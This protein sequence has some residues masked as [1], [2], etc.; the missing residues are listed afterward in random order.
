M[1]IIYALIFFSIFKAGAQSVAQNLRRLVELGE[2]NSLVLADSCIKQN[3]QVDSAHFYKGL[4]YLK[5]NNEKQTLKEITWLKNS[6]EY[7]YLRHYLEGLHYFQKQNYGRAVDQ[8][9]LVLKSD[10][11][12]LKSIYNRALASGLLEDYR[13][14]IEDLN[15]CIRKDPKNSLYYYARA[16]WRE[17]S[18]ELTEAIVDYEMSI[19]KNTKLFDAYIGLANCYHLQK[20]L[21]K[22]CETIDRAEVAGSQSAADLRQ[23]YCK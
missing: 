18:G 4:F 12:H 15:V 11:L 14:A 23:A 19:S 13:A 2:A 5:E 6:A 20:N 10:S 16:Y 21:V 3:F 22:A 17:I 9:N 8:F 7:F 1:K